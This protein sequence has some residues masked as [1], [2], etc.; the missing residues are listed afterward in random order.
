MGFCV[1]QVGTADIPVS[2]GKIYVYM[3]YKY[4]C[5][6]GRNICILK[7]YLF[8]SIEGPCWCREGCF[9]TLVCWT[10]VSGNFP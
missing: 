9:L 6:K 1:G 5:I 7:S 10:Q 2:K 8:N 4:M 3:G